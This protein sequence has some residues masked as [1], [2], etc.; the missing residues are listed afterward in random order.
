MLQWSPYVLAKFGDVVSMHPWESCQF[1]PPPKIA[2]ENVLNSQYLSRGLLDFAK[3]CTEFKRITPEMPQKFKVRRSKVKV[4]AWHNVCKSSQNYQLSTSDCLISLKFCTDF[5]HVTLDVPRTFKVN[6]PK[7]KVTVWQRISIKNA[8][9]Q[10]RISCRRSNLVK[11]IPEPSASR[12]AMFK[13]IR[14]NNE[15][16]ITPD[17]SIAFKFGTEFYHVTGDTLQ[18][19]KVKGQRSRSQSQRS[20]SHRKVMYHQQTHYST[21]TDRFGDIKPGMA[22]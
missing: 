11:I 20:R 10:A 9:I 4:T 2:R 6:A 19:F 18:M 14:S 22:S 1:C 16:A 17:C 13:V 7:V 12:N 8:I 3:I 21:A 15:I 5:D